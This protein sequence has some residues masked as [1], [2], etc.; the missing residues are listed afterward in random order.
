MIPRIEESGGE[1]GRRVVAGEGMVTP[2]RELVITDPD[3]S[4]D[5]LSPRRTR[6][7]PDA[8]IVRERPELFALCC[9][10]DRTDAPV[11]FARRS[12]PRLGRSRTSSP[13]SRPGHP[14]LRH[15]RKVSRGGWGLDRWSFM[16]TVTN[17]ATRRRGPRRADI[18]H[19]AHPGRPGARAVRRSGD[20]N[21]GSD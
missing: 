10:N 16:A 14:D 15:R 3:G 18:A 12:A 9:K 13:T 6:L 17:P 4:E 7:A 20:R 2:I 11:V 21:Q 8:E 19:I 5:V 1:H